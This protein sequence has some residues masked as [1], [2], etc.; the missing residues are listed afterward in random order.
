MQPAILRR[1]DPQKFGQ[2]LFGMFAQARR[3]QCGDAR[4]PGK[5]SGMPA[6]STVPTPACGTSLNIGLTGEHAGSL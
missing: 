2:H 1:I 3:W 5:S 6:A 4:S